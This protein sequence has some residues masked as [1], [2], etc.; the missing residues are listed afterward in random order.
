MQK[1]IQLALVMFKG[2]RSSQAV[3]EPA[4]DQYS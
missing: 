1:E 3:Q 2:H 4:H